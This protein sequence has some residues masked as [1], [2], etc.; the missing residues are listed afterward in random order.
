MSE[1]QKTYPYETRLNIYYQQGEVVD[2]KAL[3]PMPVFISGT[4]RLFA[5]WNVSRLFVSASWRGITTG[6]KQHDDDDEFFYV[7]GGKTLY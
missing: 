3:A 7:V 6:T 1:T 5:R 4:T 2:E